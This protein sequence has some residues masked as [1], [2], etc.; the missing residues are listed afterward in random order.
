MIQALMRGENV[1]VT[2]CC[3]YTVVALVLIFAL[4][5]IKAAWIYIPRG[6]PSEKSR[7]GVTLAQAAWSFVEI[8]SL[9]LLF[10]GM[11]SILTLRVVLGGWTT[12][13][14]VIIAGTVAIWPFQEWFFHAQLLH[15]EPIHLFG[16]TFEPI[17]VKTH[18]THH[19]HPRELG[20]GVVNFYFVTIYLLGLP[21]VWHFGLPMAPAL[22]GVATSLV[23]LFAYEW[24]HFLIHTTYKPKSRWF[25][26]LWR[27][28]RL[29]HFKNEHHWYGVTTILADAALG[30]RPAKELIE[31]SHTCLTLGSPEE[32]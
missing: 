30:T 31:N 26:I 25:S 32:L 28:H 22:T 3:L 7:G 17:F 24:V 27:N 29:H 14:A 2:A 6:D 19:Y 21:M 5:R 18:R 4:R 12:W 8:H 1:Y 9:Q 10:A 13:D 11:A 15:L 23:L 16:R 20:S